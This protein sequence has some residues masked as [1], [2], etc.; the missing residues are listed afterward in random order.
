[1]ECTVLVDYYSSVNTGMKSNGILHCGGG[2]RP[3]SGAKTRQSED[4]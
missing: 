1:M 4:L 3:N 2:P